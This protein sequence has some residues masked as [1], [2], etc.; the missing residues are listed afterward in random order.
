[1]SDARPSRFAVDVVRDGESLDAELE[2][3][4]RHRPSGASSRVRPFGFSYRR[5]PDVFAAVGIGAALGMGI[6]LV[7]FSLTVAYYSVVARVVSALSFLTAAWLVARFVRNFGARTIVA[8]ESGELVVRDT[9]FGHERL[10][11]RFPASTV[12]DVR[13]VKDDG[14]SRVVLGGPRHEILGEV[15]R[16]KTLDPETLAEWFARM[17]AIVARRAGG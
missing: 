11:R 2:R 12:I 8:A 13:V 14:T 9:V 17:T 16:L 10:A 1:M 7:E 4:E 5:E 15:Y 3:L 6:L